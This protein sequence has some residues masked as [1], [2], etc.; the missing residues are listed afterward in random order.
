M[1][2]FENFTRH[3]DGGLVS[4]PH[5]S[6]VIFPPSLLNTTPGEKTCRWSV[7]TGVPSD[8]LVFD[9]MDTM[10]KALC[11]LSIASTWLYPNPF[12]N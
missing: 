2:Y 12:H 11:E 9:D 3:L 5:L 4:P 8:L 6:R 7:G 1:N 10:E